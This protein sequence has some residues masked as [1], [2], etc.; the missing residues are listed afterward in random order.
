MARKVKYPTIQGIKATRYVGIKG[1]LWAIFSK[2]IRKRDF[3]RYNGKCVSCPSMLDDWKKGDAGHYISV[4]RGNFDTLF[5]EKNV[6]LQCKKCNNPSWTP[7]ASIPFA[8]E[9]DRRYGEGTADELFKRSNKVGKEY[10]P[11]EYE[12]KIAYYKDEFEN[13]EG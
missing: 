7:D 13:L 10:S 5:D 2:Y 6:A 3:L 12:E 8:R 4:S 9:L 1:V 11:Q